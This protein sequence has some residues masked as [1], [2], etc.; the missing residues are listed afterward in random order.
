MKISIH[1]TKDLVT[2]SLKAKL[3]QVQNPRPA[4]E[5]MG[6]AVVSLAKRSFSAPALRAAPWPALKPATITAKKKAG[7]SE[8]PLQR[9]GTLAKSPRI[10]EV[11]ARNVTV[12]SDREAG[13]H[14]LAA[15]HQLGAPAAKIPARPIFPFDQNGRPTDRARRNVISAAQGALKLQK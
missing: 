7:R 4:L 8:K 1:K 6:L 15:I 9:T 11:T 14:S 5:A 3:R 2:P 10:I 13:S 12:G